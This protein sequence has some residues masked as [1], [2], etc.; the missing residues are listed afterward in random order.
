[1]NKLNA[2]LFLTMISFSVSLHGQNNPKFVFCEIGITENYNFLRKEP[3]IYI[4]FGSKELTASIGK[5]MVDPKTEKFIVLK[6]PID[7]LNY[8]TKHG[9]EFVQTYVTTIT[10]STIIHYIMKK[11]FEELDEEAKLI[12]MK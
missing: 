12:L 8:M 3:Y 10:N 1:M 6:T 2:V 7:A 9:W 5:I 4:D 11:P